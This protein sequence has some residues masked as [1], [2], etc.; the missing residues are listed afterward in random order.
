[1]YT[2]EFKSCLKSVKIPAVVPCFVVVIW[3]CVVI[4]RW[5]D[6]RTVFLWWILGPCGVPGYPLFVFLASILGGLMCGVL[7]CG[8]VLC[9]IFFA[10]ILL[11]LHTCV[12][13]CGVSVPCFCS[14]LAIA[15]A[16]L[17]ILPLCLYGS[18]MFVVFGGCVTRI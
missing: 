18:G 4:G 8:H 17:R 9:F 13:L 5:V 7:V 6:L 16:C 12:L 1:M 3:G 15:V 2:N 14:P 10:R 11:L